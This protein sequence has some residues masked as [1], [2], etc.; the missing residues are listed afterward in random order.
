[1]NA[2]KKL[3]H[4]AVGAAVANVVANL[5]RRWHADRDFDGLIEPDITPGPWY[6]YY[7]GDFMIAHDTDL[8][9]S[10]IVEL[11]DGEHIWATQTPEWDRDWFAEH[12]GWEF[13][14]KWIPFVDLES[15]DL[16]ER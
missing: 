2:V 10:A 11:R 9:T 14:A 8:V 3:L 15:Q 4:I 5:Y 12:M 6:A 13:P 7:M 16:D 1:M